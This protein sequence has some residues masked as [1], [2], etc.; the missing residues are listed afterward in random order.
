MKKIVLTLIAVLTMST[1]FAENENTNA[2]AAANAYVMDVN[3]NSLSRAL[4]LS[5]DQRDAVRDIHTTFCTEMLNAAT[6]DR[7]ERASLTH[8][9]V[10][11]DLYLLS[12]VLD[13]D[14]MRKYMAILNATFRNRGLV[15]AE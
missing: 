11:H 15:V 6:A 5:A 7:Q 14:Q 10:K 13:R 8:M 2:V 3:M 9:A 4:S 12:V 1:A